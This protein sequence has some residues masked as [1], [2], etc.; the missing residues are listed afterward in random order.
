VSARSL[1]AGAALAVAAPLAA[2]GKDATKAVTPAPL[3]PGWT[4]TM[5][6]GSESLTAKF[7]KTANGFQVTS[8]GAAIYY[9]TSDAQTNDKFVTMANFQQL[10]KNVGHGDHGEAF[11]LFAG[12]HDLDDSAKQT[13]YYFLIRQDGQFLINHRAG[14]E[15]HKIV[16]WTPNPAIVKLDDKPN[17]SN[18]LEIRAGTDSVRF[19]VNGTVVHA[20][21]RKNIDLS[22]QTGIRV[23][24]NLD[25]RIWNFMAMK[26]A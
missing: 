20:L 7:V 3:P 9:T 2:Q 26:G 11:G 24:H 1:I 22:G 12:G 8:G 25:V 14:K 19:V 6:P 15:V 21:P 13:Y 5:D 17:A 4:M 10:Q 18:S 16:D 23:N